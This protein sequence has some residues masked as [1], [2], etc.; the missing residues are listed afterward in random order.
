M[1][2]G[3]AR[4]TARRPQR[5]RGRTRRSLQARLFRRHGETGVEIHPRLEPRRASFVPQG[6][7]RVSSWAESTA[8][9][10]SEP[11]SAL[12]HWPRQQLAPDRQAAAPPSVQQG[13]GQFPRCGLSFP[14]SFRFDG[15]SAWP[16]DR[17]DRPDQARSLLPRSISDP[18]L[19][20]IPHPVSC[21]ADSLAS[22]VD[23]S[24]GAASAFFPA[25][26]EV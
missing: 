17:L 1:W 19:H 5:T 6:D 12:L 21:P 9:P 2:G 4:P 23:E 20:R 24:D 22:K 10:E 7:P 18:A 15:N 16:P 26:L 14:A 11:A 25:R 13:E 3:L 8:W